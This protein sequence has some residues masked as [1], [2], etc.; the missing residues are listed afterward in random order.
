MLIADLH[1][2]LEVSHS[3]IHII[4]HSLG[5]HVA[6]FTGA[7]V[8]KD[9]GEKLPRI[10]GLDPAGPLFLLASPQNRLDPTDANFVDVIHTDGRKFGYYN[11]LGTVDFYPNGGIGP[12][13]ACRG[14]N[15]I[16]KDISKYIFNSLN[17][18]I[19]S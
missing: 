10:T 9:K 2:N 4:G 11:P 5:A 19:Y 14:V 15:G 18:G 8:Q 6:G 12:Q 16:V 1:E 17:T 7:I 3:N 13:P